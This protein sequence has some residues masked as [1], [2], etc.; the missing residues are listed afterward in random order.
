VPHRD[1]PRRRRRSIADQ[2]PAMTSAA[3][4]RGTAAPGVRIRLRSRRVLLALAVAVLLFVSD[5]SVVDAQESN[6]DASCQILVLDDGGTVSAQGVSATQA[7][8][9]AASNVME[10]H[11]FR[12]ETCLLVSPPPGGSGGSYRLSIRPDLCGRYSIYETSGGYDPSDGGVPDGVSGYAWNPPSEGLYYCV[13]SSVGVTR[14]DFDEFV[15][16][17]VIAVSAERVSDGS[18]CVTGPMSRAGYVPVRIPF[19][20]SYYEEHPDAVQWSSYRYYLRADYFGYTVASDVEEGTVTLADAAGQVEVYGDPGTDAYHSIEITWISGNDGTEKRFY[21]Y[22]DRDGGNWRVFEARVYN[23]NGEWE[24]FD[25]IA[26]QEMT[27]ELDR[28]FR[29]ESLVLTNPSGSTIRFENITLATFLLWDDHEALKE[30]IGL[31]PDVSLIAEDAS[32]TCTNYNVA[33]DDEPF[34]DGDDDEVFDDDA[35]TQEEDEIGS[36]IGEVDSDPDVDDDRIP[37]DDCS[38]NSNYAIVF[39]CRPVP[40]AVQWIG[41]RYYLRADYFGYTVAGEDGVVTTMGGTDIE[42]SGD[43]GWD[44]YMSI[45]IIWR[46]RFTDK[47]KRLFAYFESDPDVMNSTTSVSA[48]S[49]RRWNMF[50]A[51]VYD[52]TGEWKSFENLQGIVSGSRGECFRRDNLSISHVDGSEIRF[53]NLTLAVF[54][55]WDQDD[56]SSLESCVYDGPSNSSPDG[57]S[58]AATDPPD[59]PDAGASSSSSNS[60]KRY[61]PSTSARGISLLI[62]LCS[63]VKYA[64]Y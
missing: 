36:E 20:P 33:D 28:C 1:F 27:G 11:P 44:A 35:P 23:V 29:R 41:A 12:G 40:P 25:G 42:V 7:D 21:A 14:I 59:I 48:L 10:L 18:E 17:S 8:D 24:F 9:V 4:R 19:D 60:A 62:L 52:D 26:L 61:T 15:S 54:L 53:N 63:V 46:T 38:A 43:P 55:P 32:S 2:Q 58:S 34:E 22:I 6:P 37:F 47:E 64:D 56:P 50:E 31:D 3:V 30:C 13:D 57:T 51:R 39:P 5:N 49:L 45:E 16:G